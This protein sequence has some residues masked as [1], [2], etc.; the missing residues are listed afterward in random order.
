MALAAVAQQEGTRQ[1]SET[2]VGLAQYVM[3]HGKNVVYPLCPYS[4]FTIEHRLQDGR[5]LRL[6]LMGI[7]RSRYVQDIPRS[8]LIILVA[9]VAVGQYGFESRERGL[10]GQFEE[11]TLLLGQ[12][13]S[14]DSQGNPRWGG[15]D[16]IPLRA[17]MEESMLPPAEMVFSQLR[18]ADDC[19]RL[20]K[21]LPER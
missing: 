2:S 4:K 6:K 15:R 21:E 1:V 9:P 17:P 5:E 10:C 13:T 8:E 14:R 19:R 3:E 7:D 20:L 11:Y 18:Y 12:P 16:C